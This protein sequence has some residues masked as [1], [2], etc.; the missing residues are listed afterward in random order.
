MPVPSQPNRIVDIRK[1]IEKLKIAVM[2]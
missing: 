1:V 2:G